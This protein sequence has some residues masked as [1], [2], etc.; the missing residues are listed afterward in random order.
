MLHNTQFPLL[1]SLQSNFQLLFLYLLF[2]ILLPLRSSVA[3]FFLLFFLPEF[4]YFQKLKRTAWNSVFLFYP[5]HI[6]Y[7]RPVP[8]KQTII[9]FR[10]FMFVLFSLLF[11]KVVWDTAWNILMSS[12]ASW[13]TL[14]L[15][16]FL[17]F[18]NRLPAEA[19]PSPSSEF[20]RPDWAKPRVTWSELTEEPALSSRLDC[21]S[22]K[23]L[24]T[25]MVLGILTWCH[26][27]VSSWTWWT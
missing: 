3:P 21:R 5:H 12:H 25:C 8:L 13:K 10:L 19:V 24:S 14:L 26:N 27:I 9:L 7:D 20:L 16:N 17:E 4:L 18:K 23:G 1:L 6:L 2:Q 15:L 11:A 22:S